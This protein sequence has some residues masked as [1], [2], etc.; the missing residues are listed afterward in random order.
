MV[1]VIHKEVK[2]WNDWFHYGERILKDVEIEKFD[3]VLDRYCIGTPLIPG[4][5]VGVDLTSLC[6]NYSKK[7]VN[8]VYLLRSDDIARLR[9][10]WPNYFNDFDKDI[11]YFLWDAGDII[12]FPDEME[13]NRRDRHFLDYRII[14]W[15]M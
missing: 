3:S 12:A 2:V 11:G 1:V 4:E 7:Y 10:L 5:K 8:S 14:A 13:E 6:Y 15:T 9:K